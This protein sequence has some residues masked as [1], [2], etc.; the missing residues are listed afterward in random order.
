MTKSA[1]SSLHERKGD[2]ELIKRELYEI[3]VTY[4]VMMNSVDFSEGELLE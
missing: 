4:L 1:P 3:N 2:D